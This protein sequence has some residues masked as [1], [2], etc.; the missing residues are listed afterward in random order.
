MISRREF[1]Q[2]LR[3]SAAF[4]PLLHSETWGSDDKP[5]KRLLLVYSANGVLD[6][7]WWPTTRG[8]LDHLPYCTEVLAPHRAKLIFVDDLEYTTAYDDPLVHGGHDANLHM[9]TGRKSV[10]GGISVDKQ[11][12]RGGA[13]PSVDQFIASEIAKTVPLRFPSL[14]CGVQVNSTNPSQGRW[15]YSAPGVPVSPIDNPQELMRMLFGVGIDPAQLD[16]LWE[17]NRSVLDLVGRDLERYA[18]RLAGEDQHQVQSHL[19]SIRALERQLNPTGLTL[20]A[21]P[22]ATQSEIAAMNFPQLAQLQMQIIAH[23]FACDLTRVATLQLADSGGERLVFSWLEGAE[24]GGLTFSP[25]TFSGQQHHQIAH[26]GGGGDGYLGDV[27]RRVDRWFAE[28]FASF[29]SILDGKPVGAQTLLDQTAMVW[30]NN[31]SN[32]A[33]HHMGRY[34]GGVPTIIAGSCG[35]ALRTG[36]H[37]I[38]G[39]AKASHT[40]LLTSLCHAMD[41][42]IPHFGDSAYGNGPLGALT[43]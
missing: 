8:S 43:G 31:M 24:H 35:G 27:K 7:S 3:L 40:R 14:T 19:E 2:R 30:M 18:G 12:A 15:V 36:R 1:L 38:S 17:E 42:P 25:G 4:L 28:L 5:P 29:C 33:G 9:L 37:A 11:T 20:C 6:Q 26:A 39:S 41:V 32:G 23:A 13:G 22:T 34:R 16:R 10:P 21:H